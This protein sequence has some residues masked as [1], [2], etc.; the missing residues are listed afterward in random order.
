MTEAA[1]AQNLGFQTEAKRLLH[2]MIHSMY[3]NR[4]FFLRELISNASDAADKLRFAALENAALLGGDAELRVRIDV[5]PEAHT[6]TIADSGIGMSRDEAV[7]NLGTIARSGTAEFI[8]NLSGDQKKDA[9]L[10]GQFG[11]GFYSGFLVADRIVVESRR[12]DL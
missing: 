8:G 2:M 7:A 5:D 1:Q 12:A 4:D 9:N 6:I 11:I 3:S 10:I